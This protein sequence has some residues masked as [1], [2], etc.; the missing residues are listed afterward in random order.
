MNANELARTVSLLIVI[1]AA[2]TAQ[3]AQEDVVPLNN[4][5]T[6]L[7]WQPNQ[8]ERATATKAV[9]QLKFSAN[10]VSTDALTFV[11]ITP[12]RLVDTRGAA[13]GF[14][15]IQPFAGPSIPS[16]GTLTIPVQSATEASTN[17]SPAPCGVIPSIAQGYS[18]NLTVVPAAG[19]SVGYVSLWPAGSPQPV[20]ATLTDVQGLIV[21]NAAIVPAGTPSGGVSVYNNGPAATD[22]VIDMNGYFAAPSDLNANTAIGAG[23]LA[24]N[25]NGINNTA[26][27]VAALA[28]NT[29]GGDN[30]ASGFN[31]L[32]SNTTGFGNTAIGEIA[33]AKNTTGGQNTASSAGALA[34]NTTGSANTASGFNALTSNTTGGSNTAIGGGALGFNTAGSNNTASGSAALGSNTTGNNNIAIGNGAANNVSGGN[35]NNIHIGSQGS[36]ADSGT[37]RIGTPGTQTSFYVA[38]VNGVTTT[39]SAVPVLIDTTNGQLG[40]ASSSRRYKEDIQDMGDASSGLLRLHPVTFRYRQPFAD[41]SKPIEYGL[42]A[43]EVAEVYPDLVA[44]SADGQIETVKYQVLDSMLLNELQKEHQQVQQQTEE[45]RLLQTRLAALEQLLSS[46]VPTPSPAQ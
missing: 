19:G 13:A 42:I 2:L 35:S 27:G 45:I 37:I 26:T 5:P 20:V 41:G 38:G 23:A 7:Y 6:P 12:C 17:T 36:S 1:P 33:L 10:A 4:W 46:K 44:H 14:N 40:V 3:R 22:V 32:T 11:A 29:S 16:G 21:S 34:S 30:T 8:A 28:S 31:A 24:S 15:G 9:A 39:N 25:T 43:E 18:F